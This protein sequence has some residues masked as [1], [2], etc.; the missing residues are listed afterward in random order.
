MSES[1]KEFRCDICNAQGARSMDHYTEDHERQM[2]DASLATMMQYVT[3]ALME[4]HLTDV[5][6]D[7]SRGD[8]RSTTHV[9]GTVSYWPLLSE[10]LPG[11][12]AYPVKGNDYPSAN[13][14][15]DRNASGECAMCWRALSLSES[16]WIERA[17]PH[18]LQ[19]C[20]CAG[21]RLSTDVWIYY[22]E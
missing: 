12:I 6:Y 19:C 13:V 16:K 5:C 14:L 9:P 11:T 3:K 8:D 1:P 2:R 20:A 22:A 18:R 21:D 17:E 10:D 7:V 15:T 4:A